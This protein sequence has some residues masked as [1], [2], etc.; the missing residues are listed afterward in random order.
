MVN[1]QH[2][3]SRPGAGRLSKPAD[4]KRVTLIFYVKSKNVEK[5]RAK[6]KPIIDKLN[7]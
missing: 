7:K 2:G 1:Q 3:G 5:A 4:E 6:I